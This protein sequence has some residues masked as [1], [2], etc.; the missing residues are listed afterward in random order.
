M[1][2]PAPTGGGDVLPDHC[3]QLGHAVPGP[4]LGSV[5]AAGA[6]DG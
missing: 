1:G 3:Q 5:L 6:A 4:T 2:P